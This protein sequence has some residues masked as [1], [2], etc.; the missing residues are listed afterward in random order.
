MKDRAADSA[1]LSPGRNGKGVLRLEC[2]TSEWPWAYEC[3]ARYVSR[4]EATD[5][6]WEP[7]LL[8]QGHFKKTYCQYLWY[9]RI[10]ISI[11]Y[12]RLGWHLRCGLKPLRSSLQFNCSCIT[13]LVCKEVEITNASSFRCTI[14]FMPFQLR[15]SLMWKTTST[16][17]N[18]DSERHVQAGSISNLVTR[19]RY[20][21]TW[22][23]LT[24]RQIQLSWSIVMAQ[25]MQLAWSILLAHRLTL[26]NKDGVKVCFS[27][28]SIFNTLLWQKKCQ[29]RCKIAASARQWKILEEA[30]TANM[31]EESIS[32]SWRF[33]K[34]ITK[35]GK[36]AVTQWMI[37][38]FGTYTWVIETC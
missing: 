36:K 28:C 38:A 32:Y 5:I 2:R 13:I 20:N 30:C 26:S 29:W 24:W 9:E 7:W 17:C 3:P 22:I 23:N 27:P 8:Y 12:H 4:N 1:V 15:S 35:N 31:L 11:F 14:L 16:K 25:C 19:F 6:W 34:S 33:I 37:C 21:N 10:L 18:R